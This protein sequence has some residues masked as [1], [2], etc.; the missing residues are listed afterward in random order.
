MLELN[1]RWSGFLLL[2]AYNN[3]CMMLAL[4]LL[5]SFFVLAVILAVSS[6]KSSTTQVARSFSWA[7]FIRALIIA[8]GAAVPLF[9]VYLIIYIYIPG[10]N[11]SLGLYGQIDKPPT[12]LGRII[13]LAVGLLF[14]FT[15]FL[16]GLRYYRSIQQ[17]AKTK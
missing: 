2:N 7:A 12:T 6:Q 4:V 9:V 3:A 1:H 14:V 5:I 13:S 11:V 16:I 17:S 15:D 8:V 10:N